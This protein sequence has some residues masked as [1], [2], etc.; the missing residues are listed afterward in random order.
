MKTGLPLC[1]DCGVCQGGD[2]EKWSA[3]AGCDWLT[4]VLPYECCG[5]E[6]EGRTG[7]WAGPQTPKGILVEEVFSSNALTTLNFTLLGV[8][9]L[10]IHQV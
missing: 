1:S 9:Y 7:Y 6:Q 4:L 3:G 2:E 8:I 5:V 10:F